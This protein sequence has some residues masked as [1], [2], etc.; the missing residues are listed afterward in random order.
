[1]GDV[2]TRP[3]FQG[4]TETE[5]SQVLTFSYTNV[6][7]FVISFKVGSG[8]PS[9]TFFFAGN[10]YLQTTKCCARKCN[11]EYPAHTTTLSPGFTTTRIA[12][13]TT[14]KSGGGGGV[15]TTKSG[16][17]GG[18][19]DD[20][21]ENEK[22]TTTTTALTTGTTATTTTLSCDCCSGFVLDFPNSVVRRNNLGGL[23]PDSGAETIVYGGIAKKGSTPVDLVV[24]ATSPYKSGG[25]TNRVDGA[26]GTI[27]VAG[28]TSVELKFR[29]LAH[30]LSTTAPQFFFSVFA[31]DK[32]DQ[33][34]S[35]I[36]EDFDEYLVYPDS[37]VKVE[38]AGVNG[39]T[40][41]S[42]TQP[43]SVPANPFALTE[44]EKKQVLTLSF[45]PWC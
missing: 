33:A 11:P 4:L 24:S 9:R 34:K 20:D 7:E 22:G 36:V 1:V 3:D 26:Y 15:T 43:G 29:F 42:G 16:G 40:T 23:G 32:I 2:P 6:S 5:K 44:A 31:L 28:G 21:N 14:T 45:K 17:G 38:H 27:N 10:N 41:F 35:V 8:T 13:V 18:D 12:G 39:R 37:N 25:K 30:G 19:D